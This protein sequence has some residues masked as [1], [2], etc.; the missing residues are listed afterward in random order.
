MSNLVT[1]VLCGASFDLDTD[2]HNCLMDVPPPKPKPMTAIEFRQVLESNG[3]YDIAASY[4][5]LFSS[6]YGAYLGS[7]MAG[8]R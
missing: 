5:L 4:G 2:K 6:A 3:A 7:F 8:T 1:C